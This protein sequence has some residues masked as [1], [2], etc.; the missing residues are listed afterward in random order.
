MQ[1]DILEVYEKE[2]EISKLTERLANLSF[3][4]LKKIEHFYYSIDEKGTDISL[5]EKNFR[6]FEKIKIAVKRKHK[7]G[8]ISYDFYYELEDGTY[9]VYAISLENFPQLLNGFKVNR[10]FRHFKKSLLKAYRKQLIG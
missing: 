5:L 9:L 4:D 6:N 1:D 10:N 3:N 7:N 8:K 2:N